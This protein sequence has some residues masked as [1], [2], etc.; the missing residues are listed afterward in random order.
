[1]IF[2]T[3]FTTA[4]AEPYTNIAYACR[5]KYMD[6]TRPDFSVEVT[7]VP[8][9]FDVTVG[10]DVFARGVF[11]SIDG[12]DNF[13][14]D[15]YFDILPGSSRKIRVTTP[16]SSNEFVKQLKISSVGSVARS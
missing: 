10:S 1:M 8:G 5:Q 4:D 13:F 14:S 11:L 16:I 2:T 12:I 3:T 7:E 6:Y 15:N 9:G